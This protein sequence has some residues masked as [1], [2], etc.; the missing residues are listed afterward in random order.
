M[1]E[2]ALGGLINVVESREQQFDTYVRERERDA[3]VLAQTPLIVDAI[4]RADAIINELGSSGIDTP[5][6]AAV[7]KQL[8]KFLTYYKEASGFSDIFLICPE[9][10]AVFSVMRGEE[11]GSNYITGPY[12]N[13]ELAKVFDRAKTLLQTEV[14]DFE[15]YPATNQP[16]AFIATPI[17]KNNSVIGVI[18]LQLNNE[19]IYTLVQ[20]CTGLGQTGEIVVATRKGNKAVF[21]SPV[22]HDQHAAFRRRIEI[23]SDQAPGL[24]K[25]VLGE[26]G[27]GATVDYHGKEVLAVWRYLPRLRWGLIAKIEMDEV[28]LPSRKTEK[29]A[30]I[31]S[32]LTILGAIL[33]AVTISKAISRQIVGLTRVTRVMADGDLT[34][35]AKAQRNDEIGQLAQ[36]FNEMAEKRLLAENEQKKS[37]LRFRTLYESSGDAIMLLD[38]TGFFDCNQATLSIFGCATREEFHSLHPADVSPAKQPDERDSLTAANEAIETAMRKG[39]YRFEWLHKRL[40]TGDDFPAEVLLTAMELDGRQVLQA[41]VRDITDSKQAEDVLERAV[42]RANQLAEEADAATMAKSEFLANMSHEIRTPMNGVLGMTGLLLD[43]ELTVEQRECAEIVQTCGDSLLMLINDI[44]DFSKVEA[45]KLDMET[46]DFDLRTTVEETGDILAGKIT[47]K[48]LHLSCFV[49]P[50]TPPLL[51]G[52]PGRLRQVMINLANNAIKFTKAG[53]V[54][55]SVTLEAETPTQATIRCTV[56]DTGIGIPA[57]RMDRLFQSFSQVDASTTRKYG[58]TG[59]GLVISKQIVELMGGQIGVES[60]QGV[61]STFWFTAVLDKQPAAS[62]RA[63]VELKDIESLRVLVVDDNATNRRILRTYLAAWGCR[64]DEATCAAEAI[65]ALREAACGD[66]P[67]QIILLDNLMPGIDGETLGGQ[68]KTDLELRDIALVMLTSAGQRGDARRMHEA[69]FAAYLTKPVKQSQLLD[70]L[71]TIAGKSEDPNW[72]PPEAIVTRH[73]I[74]EDRKRRIRVLLAEDNSMNQKVALRIIEAKLGYRADA[75]ADGREAID[76]L[77]RQHYDLVLMDCHMPEMDGYEATQAIRD[78]NSSVLN[79]DIPIIAMTANAMKGD[80]EKCLESGMDDYVA[81]PINLQKLAAAIERNIPDPDR[82]SLP[83]PEGA[84]TAPPEQSSDAPCA[85]SPYDRSVAM[86]HV[87][88]DEDLFNELITIFL[89]ETPG[90]LA[91]VWSGVSS[92]DPEAITKAA[93]ALQSSLGV[94]AANDAIR[95]ALAIET[96]GKSGDLAGVQEAAAALSVEVQRLT[97]ALEQET[98]K[99]PAGES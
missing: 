87:G 45:G 70:C 13:S 79:H 90:A 21:V 36:S 77:S 40:D 12:R 16:A 30:I 24:Q 33:A 60:K 68:I 62:H 86:D 44:L 64:P 50:E 69:G 52:D 94:L 82:E 31:V 67:F 6:Y 5:Q 73:S 14:S 93:H 65:A 43:T 22:R 4:E 71:R 63:P 81:K 10:H 1:R 2:Q 66:D 55:I 9:G 48:G 27:S 98:T 83:R 88:G 41:S 3:A 78:P 7:D 26:K 97:S 59:L 34:V 99:A 74:T 37:E 75:V 32:L 29:T 72:I 76:S 91:Q 58:G 96:L 92:G 39:S 51:Q 23:G 19:E 95:T 84:D 46:I 47:N 85:Q 11:L 28:L 42:E 53:E 18:A 56:R 25:A 54:A 15:Y 35:R 38:K 17:F 49:D 80:R 57:D 61:G 20:D 8:R 89:T